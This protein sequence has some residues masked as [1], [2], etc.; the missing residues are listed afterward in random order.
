[1]SNNYVQ[2]SFSIDNL[3][4]A[5]LAWWEK[6]GLREVPEDLEPDEV[7]PPISSC[8]RIQDH[9]GEKFVWFS[10]EE[11]IDVDLASSV[12]QRFLKECRPE[13][14]V[15][16]TWAETSDKARLDEFGGGACF[17]SAEKIEWN[18]AYGWLET[19]RTAF[20]KEKA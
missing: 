4:E 6:E 14:S 19:Q 10:H 3:T 5:E 20:A 8:W 16:F 7:D 15:G 9:Q 11:S 18:S 2:S 13:G 1:M 17:I 12:I